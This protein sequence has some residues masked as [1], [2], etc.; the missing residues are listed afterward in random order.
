VKQLFTLILLLFSLLS[1]GFE[2]LPRKSFLV[3]VPDRIELD[4][5][6]MA[7]S[8][9]H[10]VFSVCRDFQG[11]NKKNCVK[12]SDVEVHKK[13][14]PEESGI[15]LS[16]ETIQR[17]A[18][19]LLL[20]GPISSYNT[21]SLNVMLVKK[22]LVGVA[23]SIFN[24]NR[25]ENTISLRPCFTE[26]MACSNVDESYYLVREGSYFLSLK[27]RLGNGEAE[28]EESRPIVEGT[29]NYYSTL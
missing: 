19:Q 6:N 26:R 11:W 28:D 8:S 17:A 4:H 18:G 23:D 13:F 20:Q 9:Y 24:G 22:N 2:V 29:L 21:I 25:W 16:A 14:A 1:F 15:L 12:V 27:G 10:L 7:L 3:F 5:S